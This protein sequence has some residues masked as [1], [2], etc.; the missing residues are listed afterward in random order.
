MDESQ[1][2]KRDPSAAPSPARPSA[3]AAIRA[4]DTDRDRVADILRDALAEGRLTA[5]EHAERIEVLYSARTMGE[6]ELLTRDL[7]VPGRAAAPSVSQEPPGVGPV[8]EPA[9]VVAVFGGATRKGR[10]RVGSEVRAFAVF[11]GVEIDL[12]E[13]VFTSPQVTVKVTAVFGGVE[14]K[15][16]EN[17]TVRGDGAVGIF[18]GF[19]IRAYEC[20]DPGAPEVRIGGVAVFGG[21]DVKRKRGQRLKEWAREQW[22]RG[23]PEAPGETR[24]RLHGGH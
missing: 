19:D 24:H 22:A 20:E 2:Q 3:D 9:T 17:V 23:R 21:A 12:T 11:G 14:V 4:S 15:V 16:P 5:E 7:P 1:P 13:A 6:L 18:G 8:A 10:W